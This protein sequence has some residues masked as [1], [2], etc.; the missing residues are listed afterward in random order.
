MKRIAIL[1]TI[2]AG[3][4]ALMACDIALPIKGRIILASLYVLSLAIIVTVAW[5]VNKS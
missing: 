1:G 3:M 5:P 4:V 2:L